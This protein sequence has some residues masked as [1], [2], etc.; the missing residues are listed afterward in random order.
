[1]R[2]IIFHLSLI[3]S[4]FFLTNKSAAQVKQGYISFNELLSVMP[5]YK[6]A[7]TSLA[8]Y[9]DALEQQYQAYQKEY[10]EQLGLITS[11][12]TI[13]YTK[14]QLDVKRQN[15]SDMYS[16][17]QGYNQQASQLLDQKRQELLVPIQKKAADAIIVVAKENG[18]LYVLEK[19][20][21][22]AYP[23]TD[24]LLPLVKKKLGIN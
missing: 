3:A 14:A 11:K 2:K 17:L 9:R 1:M 12:D 10:I 18:Y 6:K 4:L 22:H 13:K 24:D 16:K 8:Q 7:D 5:E 15:V 19:E 21:L 23:T 20:I